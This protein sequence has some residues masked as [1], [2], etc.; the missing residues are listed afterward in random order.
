MRAR[1][2]LVATLLLASL[3]TTAAA[4]STR[5]TQRK[6]EQQRRELQQAAAARRQSEAA[7]G[8]AT[9]QLRSVDEQVGTST[10]ALNDI[11]TRLQQ[12]AQRLDT[13][14][15]ER[16]AL[17]TSLSGQRAQ[18]AQMLRAAYFVGDAAPLKVM[19]AQDSVADAN[20]MLTYQRYLQR[21]RTRRITALDAQLAGLQAVEQDIVR[22]RASLA[23]DRT[24]QQRALA[25]LQRDRSERAATVAQLD[26]TVQDQATREKAIGANVQD[27]ERVL[28]QLRAAAARAE[29]ER[30]AAAARAAAAAKAASNATTGS[31]GATPPTSPRPRPPVIANATP[32][33]VGGLG[34]PVAGALLTPYGGTLPDGRHCEGLLIGAAAGTQVRAVANGKVVFSQWMS[35]YGLIAIVDHG[36]GYMSLY[37]NNDGLLRDVGSDVK[38]GDAVATVGNSGGQGVSALYFELR[39]NGQPVDPRSWLQRR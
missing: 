14:Q 27:L 32:I 20:R 38:Q 4:Q 25:Q 22:T 35:G 3:L 19:L 13:L 15:R 34:W 10:R 37:A 5:D 2:A 26:Q 11:R 12:Q 29:A 9:Q 39:R 24:Q 36:N 23:D 30:R 6:L 18:L 21:E 33:R 31:S 1:V 28:A 8:Q 17:R 16:D 7:R